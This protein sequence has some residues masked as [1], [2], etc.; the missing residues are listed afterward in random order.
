MTVEVFEVGVS[1]D[2]CLETDQVAGVLTLPS[3]LDPLIVVT[4]QGYVWA[5]ELPTAGG[6][7]HHSTK[8]WRVA[9]IVGRARRLQRAA[10]EL[11]VSW[12]VFF[13]ELPSN[14]GH[15]WYSFLKL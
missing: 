12:L 1:G 15:H 4:L 7:S 8:D 6:L 14:L 11:L 13:E 9:R 2:S 5:G 3:N 10:K